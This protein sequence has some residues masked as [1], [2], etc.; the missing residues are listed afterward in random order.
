MIEI[1]VNCKD[2]KHHEREVASAIQE[3]KKQIKKDG[4]IQE[5]RKREYYVP[6]SRKRRLKHEESIK[7]R[8]RDERKAQWNRN[9]GDV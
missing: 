3:L 8:K 7:S 4:L 9:K 5:L 2:I 6:P 1:K